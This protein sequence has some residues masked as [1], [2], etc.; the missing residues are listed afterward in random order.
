MRESQFE[1]AALC[2]LF[3]CKSDVVYKARMKFWFIF[4]LDNLLRRTPATL[5]YTIIFLASIFLALQKTTIY[6]YIYDSIYITLLYDDIYIYI[7]ILMILLGSCGELRLYRVRD[8]FCFMYNVIMNKYTRDVCKFNV[9]YLFFLML[10]YRSIG[11]E[12]ID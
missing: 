11:H 8:A 3:R 7:R 5:K 4:R 6:I 2:E 12:Y 9:K 10:F 1:I